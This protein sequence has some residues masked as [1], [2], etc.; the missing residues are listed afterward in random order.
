MYIYSIM[1]NSYTASDLQTL[2][3]ILRNGHPK[4]D[5]LDFYFQVLKRVQEELMER[6]MVES[7]I[8][9]CLKDWLIKN[10][11]KNCDNILKLIFKTEL[12]RVPLSINDMDLKW[13]AEWRLKISK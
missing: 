9:R 6:E 3:D 8:E 4:F 2:S 1:E 13:F 12:K 10:K 7:F 5:F 11:Y